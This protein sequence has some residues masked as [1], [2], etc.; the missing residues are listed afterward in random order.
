ME[1]LGKR[2][3]QRIRGCHRNNRSGRVK[4]RKWAR[5][6]AILIGALVKRPYMVACSKQK[7]SEIGRP[8]EGSPL[9]WNKPETKGSEV[10]K[11]L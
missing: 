9:D 1:V 5:N 6:G 2:K 7:W 3:L 8:E 4:H 10:E 11:K